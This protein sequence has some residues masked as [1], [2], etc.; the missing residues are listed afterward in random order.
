MTQVMTDANFLCSSYQGLMRATQKGIPVWAYKWAQAPTCPWY[1][2]IPP[3]ALPIFG[4]AHTAEI[5]YVFANVNNNPPPNGNC[6]FTSAEQQLSTEFVRFWT[7][8]AAAGNPG[9]QW[10]RFA[11]ETSQG[12]NVLNGSASATPGVVDYSICAFW[13][14]VNATVYQNSSTSTNPTTGPSGSSST[15]PPLATFTGGAALGTVKL[16]VV[17]VIVAFLGICFVLI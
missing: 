16:S 1:S 9:S 14:Q 6:N 12:L 13:N 15:G 8:M 4:A 17:A 10:P 7:S 11:T 5:P 3:F 2:V